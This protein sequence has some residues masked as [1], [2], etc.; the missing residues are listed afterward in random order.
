MILA[1]SQKMGAILMLKPIWKP[2]DR[3]DFISSKAGKRCHRNTVLIALVLPCSEY[4]SDLVYHTFLCLLVI[5]FPATLRG[6]SRFGSMARATIISSF[7][8]VKLT[9]NLEHKISISTL[10]QFSPRES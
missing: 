5:V 3:S 9:S 4:E 6:Y 1:K 8:Y 10:I 7:V 2:R